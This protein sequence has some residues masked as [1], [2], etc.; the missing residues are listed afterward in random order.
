[1]L[2]SALA[3]LGAIAAA[4]PAAAQ[5]PAN[6]FKVS[7]EGNGTIERAGTYAY[8]E[9]GYTERGTVSTDG[10]YNFAGATWLD[11]YFPT[12]GTDK[13]TANFVN[14]SVMGSTSSFTGQISGTE[15]MTNS[16]GVSK[17]STCSAPYD[18]EA[19]DI[20]AFAYRGAAGSAIELLVA[21]AAF[22]N[23]D[24]TAISCTPN[25]YAIDQTLFPMQ[26][27]FDG[28]RDANPP[29]EAYR[30]ITLTQEQLRR[31]SF[32]VPVSFK[33]QGAASWPQGGDP[34]DGYCDV[35]VPAA[36]SGSCSWNHTWTGTL[37]FTR[38]C[39]AA[40]GGTVMFQNPSPGRD[41]VQRWFS[42]GYCAGS[43]PGADNCV[44]PNV[45]GKKL[46]K[47]KRKLKRANCALGK[48]KKVASSR[49]DKG[50]VVKQK[51]KPKTVKPA[52]AKVKVKVGK[53]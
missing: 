49:G 29:H 12:A 5:E 42:N 21:P 1:L 28:E 43:G 3:V 46:K 18:S 38:V 16:N 20:F 22:A 17:G 10:S 51:P 40:E 13:Q 45:I 30:R 36:R 26:A 32:E 31:A 2:V 24:S 50:R 44:V 23:R 9:S 52:G 34:P 53:G 25:A 15:R 8:S 4:G 27:S 37:K 19:Q 47:A 39:S 41:G 35:S 6:G 48:V 11:V 14:D 33:S 7:F